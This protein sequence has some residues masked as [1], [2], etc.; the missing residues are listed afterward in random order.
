MISF[1]F[2]KHDKEANSGTKWCLLILRE[3]LYPHASSPIDLKFSVY[4]H[5]CTTYF[6]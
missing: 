5:F 3:I 4:L 6:L 2:V 1:P